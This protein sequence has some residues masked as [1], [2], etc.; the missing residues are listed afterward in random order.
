VSFTLYFSAGV[1]AAV[2]ADFVACF[3]QLSPDNLEISGYS[4]YP[5][6]TFAA[7]RESLVRPVHAKINRRAWWLRQRAREFERS[8]GI[9][10]GSLCVQPRF[11]ALIKVLK[12]NNYIEA[13][14]QNEVTFRK[15]ER[16]RA[17]LG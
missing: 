4:T 16:L 10:G 7:I 11:K 6:L 5:A 8:R 3:S 15:G 1:S 12:N 2:Y 9:I 14:R 13:M 17:P